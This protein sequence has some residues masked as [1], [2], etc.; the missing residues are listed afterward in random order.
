MRRLRWLV[1]LT[2]VISGCSDKTIINNNYYSFTAGAIAGRVVPGDPGTLVMTSDS[3]RVKQVDPSGYFVLDSL[4]T[5]VY[6]IVVIPVN[7]SRR[8]ISNLTVAAGQILSIGDVALSNF[9][10]P[11]YQSAPEDGRDSVR[12]STSIS[13]YADERVILDDLASSAT[14]TPELNGEWSERSWASKT[15]GGSQYMFYPTERLRLATDYT[16]R[17]PASVH[18]AGGG[19]LASDLV[20][21][22]TTE[23]LILKL[24]SF[25][26]G[27]N[28]GVPLMEF[29]PSLSFNV[30]IDE[31]SLTKAVRFVP[32]IQGLW[33]QTAKGSSGGQYSFM[34]TGTDPLLPETN[35]LMII[36]GTVPLDGP[37]TL[38]QT[39]TVRFTTEPSGVIQSYPQNGARMHCTVCSISLVFNA[40]MD[41]A[42]V[43]AAFSL[44]LFATDSLIPGT[45][46]WYSSPRQMQFSP[47]G[48]LI[49]GTVYTYRLAR[50]A[51]TTSGHTMS[52]DYSASFLVEEMQ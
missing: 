5:G 47:Q 50:S 16:V 37:R 45:I 36:S 11:F 20:L 6:G 15:Y 2:V 18:L 21:H 46:T 14:I 49:P 8:E 48:A 40:P 10:Y 19:T 17:I 32:A 43:R 38:P 22:F 26:S 4:P 42:S 51:Q 1:L 9:P 33:L 31:D 44:G 25:P 23:P 24:R 7:Y 41:T 13:L 52:Q 27:I 39:D 30:V 34:A 29:S 35:Y 28:G 12:L 3:V